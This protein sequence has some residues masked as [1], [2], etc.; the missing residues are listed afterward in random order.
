MSKVK[1]NVAQTIGSYKSETGE[2]KYNYLNL[3]VVIEKENGHL[4]MKLNALPLPGEKG[5]VW[6]NLY[7][8][9]QE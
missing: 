1:Y 6:L 7:P 4:S 3:G 8:T 5:E 9:E 2:K